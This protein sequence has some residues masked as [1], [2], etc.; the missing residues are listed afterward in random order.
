MTRYG[1]ILFVM[2]IIA[3]VLVACSKTLQSKC[4]G[5]WRKAQHSW[6]GAQVRWRTAAPARDDEELEKATS[7][8]LAMGHI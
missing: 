3:V 7:M 2:T 8:A 1:L 6:Q 4:Q 5:C